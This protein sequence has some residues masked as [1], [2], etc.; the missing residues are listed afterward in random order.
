MKRPIASQTERWQAAAHPSYLRILQMEL[1]L[2]RV[3][4]ALE[5]FFCRHRNQDL[6][7]ELSP[8]GEF[9]KS[10]CIDCGRRKFRKF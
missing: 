5:R 4:R 2:L 9:H 3:A 8:D 7:Y 6:H 10:L 1:Q